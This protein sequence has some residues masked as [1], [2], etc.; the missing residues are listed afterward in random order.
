MYHT[1]CVG[2]GPGGTGIVALADRLNFLDGDVDV[3]RLFRELTSHSFLGLIPG[4][5]KKI[6]FTINLDCLCRL[7]QETVNIA[8]DWV[9][10]NMEIAFTINLD[11][12]Y[13]MYLKQA[14][15]SLVT[16]Y[17]KA[18]AI[19]I[20]RKGTVPLWIATRQISRTTLVAVD[21]FIPSSLLYPLFHYHI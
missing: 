8:Q 21:C 7:R 2:L 1:V 12:L 19:D 13:W 15:I 6:A 17:L 5:T 14:I 16:E 11:L 9:I 4:V 3:K 10:N 20:T 18:D